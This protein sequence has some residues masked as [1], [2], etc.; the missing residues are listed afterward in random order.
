[1]LCVCGVAVAQP[2]AGEVRGRVV[3]AAGRPVTGGLVSAGAQTAITGTDG[4]YAL[5][6]VEAGGD[7]VVTKTGYATALGV[8]AA[9]P[10]D[11]VLVAEQGNETIEVHG[12]PP[13][14]AQ[15][16]AH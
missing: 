5:R 8:A 9:S 3:D 12:E 15:G 10:G 16:A 1:M 13:P 2:A 6:G 7:L 11:I 14:A 4:R